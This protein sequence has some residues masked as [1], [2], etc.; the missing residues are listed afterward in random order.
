MIKNT[1]VAIRKNE[2]KIIP[3]IWIN[4]EE[5]EIEFN[6]EMI[7]EGGNAHI[8]GIFLGNGN[9]TITFNTKVIHT[10]PHTKSLTTIRGVFFDRSIFKN[11][12]LVAISKGAKGADG[13]FS[14]K[15]LLF[16]DAKGRS[17]PSLEID[18][19]D[20]K[21]GHASTIG[22]PDPEQLFYLRSRGLT[23]D[24]A[25]RLIV[26]GFFEPVIQLLSINGR[27][28]VQEHI[29]NALNNYDRL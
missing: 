28:K 15:V 17:V 8:I 2:E 18:E 11:D 14:S 19:N 1:D 16:D 22:R 6:I 29:D 13:Y 10:A 21:A 5:K 26:T 24:E 9:S 20:L 23:E 7:G 4:G 25:S 3:F 12:G 27:K